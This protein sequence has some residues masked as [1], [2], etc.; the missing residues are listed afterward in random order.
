MLKLDET[1]I[2]SVIATIQVLPTPE[3]I[4]EVYKESRFK[5]QQRTSNEK[6]WTIFQDNNLNSFQTDTLKAHIYYVATNGFKDE[7]LDALCGE[8]Q[9]GF[10]KK[11]YDNDGHMSGYTNVLA[12]HTGRLEIRLQKEENEL[13]MIM[14]HSS[15]YCGEKTENTADEHAQQ[16]DSISITQKKHIIHHL[17]S[18]IYSFEQW[19]KCAETVYQRNE[20]LSRLHSSSCCCASTLEMI[21]SLNQTLLKT[22]RDVCQVILWSWIRSLHLGITSEPILG[23]SCIM[24]C[25][26]YTLQH[27][28]KYS[29]LNKRGRFIK[30]PQPH[31][32]IDD[33]VDKFLYHLADNRYVMPADN[34]YGSH[35][36]CVTQDSMA[37]EGDYMYDWL[38]DDT[39]CPYILRYT[40]DWKLLL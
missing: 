1:R 27:V 13:Q 38:T 5:M 3:E 25:L 39:W 12:A 26:E 9:V 15:S 10:G 33:R 31:A 18:L 34:N 8:L 32:D 30:E 19:I 21:V 28:P 23:G 22:S 17:E 14:Q 7:I 35:E 36:T 24:Q 4:L 37:G 6:D 20:L 2:R 40:H 29:Y 11:L 16:N